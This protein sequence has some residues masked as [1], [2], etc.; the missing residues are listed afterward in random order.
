LKQRQ[1]PTI[2]LLQLALAMLSRKPAD[3]KALF[4]RSR[5]IAEKTAGPNYQDVAPA[6]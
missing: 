4:K 6:R 5:A 1:V 3:A 2:R